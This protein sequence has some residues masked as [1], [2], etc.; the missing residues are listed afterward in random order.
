MQIFIRTIDE[1][2]NFGNNWRKLTL[3]FEL[4]V[5]VFIFV[6]TL[7]D[8]IYA[9]MGISADKQILIYAGNVLEN[10]SW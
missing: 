8:I 5:E 3:E 1:K 2:S 9:K 6:Q 4:H 7:K 10:G